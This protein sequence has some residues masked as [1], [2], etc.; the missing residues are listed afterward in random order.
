MRFC[1]GFNSLNQDAANLSENETPLWMVTTGLEVMKEHHP[2][3]R[4]KLGKKAFDTATEWN[5]MSQRID[6]TFISKRLAGQKPSNW[7][8]IFDVLTDRKAAVAIKQILEA[9]VKG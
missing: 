2:A 6:A 3:S 1:R 4:W 7:H 5:K 8:W 9:Q